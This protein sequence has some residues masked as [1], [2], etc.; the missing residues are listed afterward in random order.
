MQLIG[1][2]DSKTIAQNTAREVMGYDVNASNY[3]AQARAARARGKAA[4]VGGAINV[5]STVLG[6]AKQV[7]QMG[8]TAASA[9]GT[10]GSW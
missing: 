8:T 4:L 10:S 2:E 7:T 9:G 6:G 5:F 3:T 1:Y